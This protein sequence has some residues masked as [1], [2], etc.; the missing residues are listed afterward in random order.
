M[1]PIDMYWHLWTVAHLCGIGIPGLLIVGA[2]S[3]MAI[4][5]ALQSVY[6]FA[7]RNVY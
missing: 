6:Y 4:Y 2:A 7:S 5:S 3:W 1:T